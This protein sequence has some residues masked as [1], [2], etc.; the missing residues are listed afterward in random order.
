MAACGRP[1]V[2]RYLD[3]SL[4]DLINPSS[5]LIVQL[6]VFC[7]DLNGQL[8]DA[9]STRSKKG[10]LI[11][12]LLSGEPATLADLQQGDVIRTLN[13]KPVRDTEHFRQALA[14]LPKNSSVVLEI[15]RDG[16]IQYVAFEIE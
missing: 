15:E 14:A 1:A 11:A 12:G 7:I 6:G 13:G 4:S 16:I 9:L 3:Q 5:D 10:I 2:N 8:S